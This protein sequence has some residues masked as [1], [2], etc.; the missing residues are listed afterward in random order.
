M[1]ANVTLVVRVISELQPRRALTPALQNR[2]LSVLSGR[3]ISP[4][5][6]TPATPPPL[7]LFPHYPTTSI[8][9]S[10]YV[11]SLFSTWRAR[12]DN[13][14]SVVPQNRSSCRVSSTTATS[15]N[16]EQAIHRL[17]CFRIHMG[18]TQPLF[19]A[20]IAVQWL[21][22]RTTSATTTAAPHHMSRYTSANVTMTVCTTRHLPHQHAL[23]LVDRPS[24]LAQAPRWPSDRHEEEGRC[25]PRREDSEPATEQHKGGG[26]GW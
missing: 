12:C 19:I 5:N 26:C 15:R 3:P 2:G 4:P 17:Y 16:I 21:S 8:A 14:E 13:R 23:G 10:W 22:S 9:S 11:R 18:C 25:G 1:L 24:G 7:Q 6:D 20:S